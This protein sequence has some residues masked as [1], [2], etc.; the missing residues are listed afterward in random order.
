MLKG[1]IWVE[2]EP[3]KGST[4]SFTIPVTGDGNQPNQMA[5]KIYGSSE[6]GYKGKTILI[7]EDE[8]SNYEFLRIY[9]TRLDIKVLRARNGKEA[10]EI[11]EKIP[12]V[13]LVMMD[14]K[15][16]LLNG[17]A[18]TKIIKE[19]RPGLTIIAQTAYAMAS[20]KEEALN[21]GCDD[22]L[23]KPLQIDQLIEMLN[24]YLG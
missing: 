16:P 3:G 8:D 6:E 4:F 11:C 14:I 15:M 12:S 19:K 5:A 1:Q 10:V 7:A 22:Y 21:A 2:S 13:D 9:L 18:A 20:D 24:R 17:L 23:S